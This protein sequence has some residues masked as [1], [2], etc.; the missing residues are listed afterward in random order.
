M[1]SHERTSWLPERISLNG[2]TV[3]IQVKTASDTGSRTS[4]QFG[5]ATQAVAASEHEWFV[6]VLLPT[7]PLTP[8]AF[9]APRDQ[10]SGATWIVHQNWR[11]DPSA[12]EGKRNAG[13]SQARIE[14][15]IWQGYEDR[16]D[17]LG[18]ATSE[19]KVLLPSWLRE[20]ARERVGLVCLPVIHG[21]KHY[22]NGDQ[23]SDP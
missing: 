19:V 15:I 1:A 10:F 16:W 2:P 21:T 9:V 14:L 22:L 11:T 18:T 13:L 23:P 12:P 7:V 17:L 3:E 4:W 5:G 8:R 20:R 6:L